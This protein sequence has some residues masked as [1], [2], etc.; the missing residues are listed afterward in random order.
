MRSPLS[1]AVALAAL[2]GLAIPAVASASYAGAVDQ[3]GPIAFYELNESAGPVAADSSP[4]GTSDGTYSGGV[5]YGVQAPFADAG[6]AVTLDGTGKV[7]STLPG[8]SS[9][10]TI[11]LWVKPTARAKQTLVAHGGAWSL[12]IAGNGGAGLPPNAKRKLILRSGGMVVNSRIAIPAGTWSMVD[13]VLDQAANRVHFWLN[14]GAVAKD[15]TPP[16]GFSFPGAPTDQTLQ[17]GPAASNKQPTSFDEVALYPAM[18]TLAQVKSHF[19]ASP[20]PDLATPP[21]LSPL[22]GVKVGDTLH[23]VQGTYQSGTAVSVTDVWMRCNDSVV[24][25][26]PPC[27]AF[28]PATSLSAYTLQDLDAGFTIMVEETATNAFGTLVTDTDETDV[29]LAADGSQGTDPGTNPPPP[30][31]NGHPPVDE[32]PAPAVAPAPTPPTS[33]SDGVSGHA[34]SCVASFATVKASKARLGKRAIRL[35]FSAHTRTLKLTA[36]KRSVRQVTYRLDGR[37]VRVSKKA[38]YKAILALKGLRTGRHTLKAIVTPRTGKARTL[39]MR[40][41]LKAC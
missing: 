20:L 33:A 36:P 16:S 35:S 28:D 27:V 6:T 22:T 23:F 30:G 2:C 24:D 40:L 32:T 8:G 12:E 3:N 9:I 29:V 38:P 39:T 34:T 19:S 25:P 7:S 10:Q 1:L 26:T 18:L 4:S 14:G 5:T 21:T 11:E 31:D 41:D 15:A 13:V 17:I 37:R